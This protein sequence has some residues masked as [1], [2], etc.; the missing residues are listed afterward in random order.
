MSADLDGCPL[1]VAAD[2][3]QA[4]A[5]AADWGRAAPWAASGSSRQHAMRGQELRNRDQQPPAVVDYS[6]HKKATH[7]SGVRG[8]LPCGTRPVPRQLMIIIN[9][10]SQFGP[11]F[12]AR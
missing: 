2:H 1:P 5:G 10:G 6:R 9:G 3:G 12:T 8:F 7:P 4:P 11:A